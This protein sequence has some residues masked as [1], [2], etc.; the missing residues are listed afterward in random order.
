[1]AEL[2]H[3]LYEHSARITNNKVLITITD[4]PPIDKG[5]GYYHDAEIRSRESFDLYVSYL[6]KLADKA[7]G[8]R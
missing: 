2:N 1:M 7:F 5:Y 4:E 3:N 6:N 8:P